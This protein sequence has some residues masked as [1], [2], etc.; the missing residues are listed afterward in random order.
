MKSKKVTNNKNSKLL[1]NFPF[2]KYYYP[3]ILHLHRLKTRLILII[4]NQFL[5]VKPIW[6]DH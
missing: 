5:I 1:N 3:K 6:F 2:F 4:N